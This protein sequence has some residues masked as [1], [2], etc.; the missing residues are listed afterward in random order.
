MR[1]PPIALP[2]P[3]LVDNFST[4][5]GLNPSFWMVQTPLVQSLAQWN[6]SA[7][8]PPALAFG[9]AGMQMSGVNGPANLPASSPRAR[10]RR[11]LP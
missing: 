5:A 7:S 2:P 11:H 8:V 1:Q 3:G 6:G 9:P 10:I 4:D